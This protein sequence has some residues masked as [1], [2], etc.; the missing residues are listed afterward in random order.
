MSIT[1]RLLNSAPRLPYDEP[2]ELFAM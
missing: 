1:Y 2:V